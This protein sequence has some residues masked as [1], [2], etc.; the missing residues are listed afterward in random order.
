MET[1]GNF[2]KQGKDTNIV[3]QM[4]CSSANTFIV[5]TTGHVYS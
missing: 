5:T 1:L 2:S 4:E 3:L